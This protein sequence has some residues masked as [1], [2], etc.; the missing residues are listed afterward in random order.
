MKITL[1]RAVVLAGLVGIGNAAM[2]DMQLAKQHGCTG[3]HALD[4]KS[5]GPAFKDVAAKYAGDATA[6]TKL[7]EKV[8]NG[9]KGVWGQAAMP[10]NSP[11]V[12]TADIEKLVSFILS[13]K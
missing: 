10:A 6:Q 1:T 4:K 3:C 7:V 11:R 9:G 2:A 13:I 12:P 8:K 5:V